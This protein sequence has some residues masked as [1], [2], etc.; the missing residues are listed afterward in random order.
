MKIKEIFESTTAGSIATVAMPMG[1]VI[2]RNPDSFFGAVTT[3][4]EFPNTPDYMK[5]KKKKNAK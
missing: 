5:K 4:E 2:K 3:S 1:G